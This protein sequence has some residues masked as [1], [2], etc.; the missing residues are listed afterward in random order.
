MTYRDD[1][2]RRRAMT[3]NHGPLS[4]PV[5]LPWVYAPNFEW[6]VVNVELGRTLEPEKERYILENVASYGKQIGRISKA[7]AVVVD[8]LLTE[9]D[10]AGRRTREL[11]AS[12]LS[13]DQMFALMK[14]RELVEEVD[15]CKMRW[16]R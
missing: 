1:E 8:T 13:S 5:S 15:A 3:V 12:K 7:L 9:R 2:G 10:D 4:G 16:R 11:D 6:G 14:L